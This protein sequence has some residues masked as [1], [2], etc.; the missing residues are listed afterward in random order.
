M[1]RHRKTRRERK[2]QRKIIIAS[3][4]G[5]LG[6]MTAGYAAFQTNLNITAK[7]NILKK[8]ITP[9][10]LKENIVTSGPGL[11]KDNIEENK[12]VYKGEDPNNYIKLDNDLW[13]IISIEPDNTL[14]I[15][16]KD[17]IGSFVYDPGYSNSISG[18]TN[19]NSMEGTRW[20]S[21]STDYCYY[22]GSTTSYSGC[23]V[24]GS[25]T[26]MLD[27]NG[28]SITKMPREVGESTTY[29]LPEKEA[30]LNTYLNTTYYASLSENTK[31]KIVNH[32]F[33]VG[34]LT[35]TSNQKLFTD[36]LR[37]KAYTWKGKVGLPT[38]TDYV[39]ASTDASCTSI[40]AGFPRPYPCKNTNYMY[41]SLYDW[42]TISP[43][44]VTRSVSMWLVSSNG[45]IGTNSA[46]T[47]RGVH[48]VVYLS[49]DI[50]LGG[51]GSSNEP[52]TIG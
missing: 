3:M 7:G 21:V 32:S 9:N 29:N 18:V 27:A 42:W 24:W 6:L 36:I 5:M 41:T 48:P 50:Q 20:S 11:Y 40:Y 47:T 30:Y 10:D 2:K 44:M 46:N 8:G 35:Y 13:R 43:G 15:I 14:K 4:I 16:K 34:I 39:R 38:A 12:Y 26:T 22:N 51:S 17:G 1:R 37:E 31:S 25:K 33:N 23:N 28:N 49:S 19:A 45:C 52:F